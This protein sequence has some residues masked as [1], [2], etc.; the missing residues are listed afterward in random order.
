MQWLLEQGATP[1]AAAAQLAESQ[2]HVDL[3]KL[4]KKAVK[5]LTP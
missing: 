4:V 5:V 1:T 3:V 2:G